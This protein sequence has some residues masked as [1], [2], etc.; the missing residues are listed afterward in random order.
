MTRNYEALIVLNTKGIDG[1]VDDL[2]SEIGKQ[3]E[4]EG[5]TLDEVQQL[6]RR[7]FAYPRKHVD[8][9]HYVNFRFS[10]EPSAIKRIESR[11]KLHDHVLLQH[12]RVK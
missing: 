8:G 1:S 11:L 2:V 10:A 12:Y 6:G 3:I 4:N 9:G 7:Q 5:G